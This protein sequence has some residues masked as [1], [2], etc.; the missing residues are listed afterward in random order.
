[1]TLA[2]LGLNETLGPGPRKQEEQSG[3]ESSAA[4]PQSRTR[5]R[6]RQKTIIPDGRSG[7]EEF[8]RGRKEPRRCPRVHRRREWRPGGN[9]VQPMRVLKTS[10]ESKRKREEEGVNE[11]EKERS[12]SWR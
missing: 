4:D 12:W 9:K 10:S 5:G 8:M 1:V 2:S 7:T 3:E 11:R 6:C